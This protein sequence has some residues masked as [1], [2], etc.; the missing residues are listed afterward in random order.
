MHNPLPQT[1]TFG[2]PVKARY[3]KLDATAPAGGKAVVG[4]DE[5]GVTLVK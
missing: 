3:I 1:V 4:M 2:K 5:L